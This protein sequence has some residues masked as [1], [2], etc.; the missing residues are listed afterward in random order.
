MNRIDRL[1]KE[2]QKNILSV[3]ITAGYPSI[4]STAGIVKS[5]EESGTDMVEIGMPFSDPMADGPV[6]QRS[7]EEALRNGMSLKVLFSQ[8]NDIRK[9]VQIPL[10]LMGYLNP[11]IQFGMEDFC[12]QCQETGIDGVILPD[13]PPSVYMEEYFN[14]FEKYNLFNILLISPQSDNDRI[15]TID[16]ISRGFI[17]MVSSSSVTGVRTNFSDD[18]IS[19]FKRV[20]DMKLKNPGLIGFG[21]SNRDTF[22]SACQYASGGIIGSAFVKMVGQEG[23]SADRIEGFVKEIKG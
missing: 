18:Q 2:K 10:L 3:Y 9:D 17:Y 14:I 23:N 7:N 22:R 21:I 12:R 8:L 6:I 11:V 5:L 20:R 4:D 19:Y 15:L 16:N 1:F 13:M